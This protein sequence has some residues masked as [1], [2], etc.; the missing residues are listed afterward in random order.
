MHPTASSAVA[1][2]MHSLARGHRQGRQSGWHALLW[3][4]QLKWCS[5]LL[6][7]TVPCTVCILSLLPGE[8]SKGNEVV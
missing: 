5:V 7:Y 2:G 6:V 4:F 3:P 1:V 8:L